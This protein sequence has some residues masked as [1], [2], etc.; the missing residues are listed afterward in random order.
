MLY[1]LIACAALSFAA[2]GL[3]HAAPV[4]DYSVQFNSGFDAT[5]HPN[6]SFTY[7]DVQADGLHTYY[8]STDSSTIRVG[9]VLTSGDQYTLHLDIASVS[10]TD[11]TRKLVDFASQSSDAGVYIDSGRLSFYDSL[12]HLTVQS[13]LALLSP[14]EAFQF[15]LTRTSAG[16]VTAYLNGAAQFTFQDVSG[17]ATFNTAGHAAYVLTD[18]FN[19]GYVPYEITP[20]VVRSIS[21]Y[22][23]AL[24]AGEV[25]SI[26]VVPEP[27][28]PALILAGVLCM[29]FLSKRRRG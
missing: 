18:D 27:S 5:A 21:V 2:T 11:W 23:Q 26:S 20:A 19:N 25:A 15:T 16:D 9:N 8:D 13:S 6:L 24:S 28:A 1:R 7:A 12:G 3:T 29:G 10:R 17:L 4:A 22:N 14:G